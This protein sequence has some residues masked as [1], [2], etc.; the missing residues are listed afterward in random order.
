M[1]VDKRDER[2]DDSTNVTIEFRVDLDSLEGFR[3][4]V[5]ELCHKAHITRV[6]G[7]NSVVSDIES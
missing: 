6:E 2:F 3:K 1:A 5:S 7:S 4:R